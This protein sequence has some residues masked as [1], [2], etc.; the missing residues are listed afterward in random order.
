MADLLALQPNIEIRAHIVAPPE[1]REKVMQELTRPVF[2]LLEGRPLSNACTYLPYDAISALASE[3]H[4]EHMS[5]SIVDSFIEEAE[6]LDL[7]ATTQGRCHS[8]DWFP[9]HQVPD[10]T[11]PISRPGVD[12]THRV[13]APSL[14]LR[15]RRRKCA[16]FSVATLS[17]LRL[18]LTQSAP[19]TLDTCPRL[20]STGPSRNVMAILPPGSSNVTSL[21]KHH[22]PLS[23]IHPQV[24]PTTISTTMNPEHKSPRNPD[25]P[26]LVRGTPSAPTAHRPK[27]P[28]S[29]AQQHRKK[30]HSTT[31]A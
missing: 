27:G 29:N 22:I 5:D 2:T 28:S 11:T 16:V 30:P 8:S 19:S 13:V 17:S 31:N 23:G 26:H 21:R 9:W 10:R 24:L 6:P 3:K 18:T 7:Y 14:P 20:T 1:R 12:L 25:R 15:R 4:L